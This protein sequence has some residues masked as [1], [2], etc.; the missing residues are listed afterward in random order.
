MTKF[1]MIFGL[2]LLVTTTGFAASS[3]C[4]ALKAELQA[5]QKAQSQIMKSMV[6]NHESFASTME[7]YSDLVAE[8]TTANKQI[9]QQ[10]DKSA[11]AFRTRGVQAK[12]TAEKLERATQELVQ[13]VVRCL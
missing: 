9:S 5:M 7:E 1:M 10:M 12:K 3:N 11:S 6:S 2:S 4:Q 13:K 8:G